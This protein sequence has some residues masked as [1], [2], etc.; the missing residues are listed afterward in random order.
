MYI[1]YIFFQNFIIDFILIKETEIFTRIK[2]KTKNCVLATAIS[3]IYVVIMIIFKISQMDYFICKILLAFLINYIAFKPQKI[4]ELIKTQIMFI[5]VSVINVGTII[6]IQN[7]IRTNNKAGFLKIIIYLCGFGISKLFIERM[8]K[9]YK[10][11]VKIN[12]VIFDVTISL[13]NKRYKYKGLLDTGNTV[14]SYTYNLPVIFAE[15]PKE[16]IPKEKLKSF[17]I[18]TV[19]LSNKCEK[20]A[21]IIDN[22]EIKMNKEIIKTKAG[23]VFENIK[24]SKN[25]DYNMVLNYEMFIENLGGIKI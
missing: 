5:M 21:Y 11:E 9:L 8:W 19:S 18:Q 2:T 3:S 12:N 6:V 22:V 20:K 24:L 14:F 10:H 1:D 13:E 17:N 16:K 25:N 7:L 4:E 23:V 15:M